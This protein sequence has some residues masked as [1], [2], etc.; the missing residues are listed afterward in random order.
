V[1]RGKVHDLG[2]TL[3]YR[4]DGMRVSKDWGLT[5]PMLVSTSIGLSAKLCPDSGNDEDDVKI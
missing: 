4:E 3:D 1:R 2:M 5:R